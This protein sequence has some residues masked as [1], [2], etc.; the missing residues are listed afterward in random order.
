MK[1]TVTMATIE[2]RDAIF[3]YATNLSGGSSLDV[4][5][6]RMEER[7]VKQFE[8]FIRKTAENQ[9][10]KDWFPLKELTSEGNSKTAALSRRKSEHGTST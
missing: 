2:D 5:L 6:E 8:K 10:Y 4:V 3:T 1:A 7:R 9:R